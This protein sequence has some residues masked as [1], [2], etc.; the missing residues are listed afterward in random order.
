MLN[1]FIQL[2]SR[3]GKVGD[4]Q[5]CDSCMETLPFQQMYRDHSSPYMCIGIRVLSSTLC[6]CL[7]AKSCLTPC[8]PM[9]YS[10]PG[11]CPWD[12]RGKNMGVSC[13]FL[14]QGI[15]PTWGLNIGRWLLYRWT[16]RETPVTPFRKEQVLPHSLH[17]VAEDSGPGPAVSLSHLQNH[18]KI[19]VLLPRD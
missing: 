13:H 7:V 16:I 9:N 3:V 4:F 1:T 5:S 12:F 8:D 18:I 10:L 17:H 2:A 19:F 6:C 14:L 15:F 11:S